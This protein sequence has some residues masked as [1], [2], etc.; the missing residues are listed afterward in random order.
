MPPACL[1]ARSAPMDQDVF[2]DFE[3]LSPLRSDALL[4]Y[5]H[6]TTPEQV[7]FIGHSG[8]RPTLPLYRS[9]IRV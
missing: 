9:G 3:N 2:A 4:T 7:T 5:V 1:G 6:G 8:R